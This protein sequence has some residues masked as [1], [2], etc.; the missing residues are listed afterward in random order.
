MSSPH[1]TDSPEI[2]EMIFIA[3]LPLSLIKESINSLLKFQNIQLKLE[4]LFSYPD[5][6]GLMDNS[7]ILDVG[8][9]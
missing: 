3:A 2:V 9:N 7:K 5:S 8:D 1:V 6:R 4:I